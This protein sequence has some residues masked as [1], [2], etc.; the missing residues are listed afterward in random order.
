MES[1][2]RSDCGQTIPI[3]D[4]G[5]Y[6]ESPVNW[7]SDSRRLTNSRA[8]VKMCLATRISRSKE[9]ADF[10]NAIAVVAVWDM[11]TSGLVE[12]RPLAVHALYRTP[13]RPRCRGVLLLKP[14]TRPRAGQRWPN[15]FQTCSSSKF[16][17]AHCREYK[18]ESNST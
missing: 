15:G 1:H 11:V 3:V 2:P 10:S 18:S 17:M 8:C 6:L 7:A 5:R 14:H 4:P 12:S 13:C 9:S 16:R